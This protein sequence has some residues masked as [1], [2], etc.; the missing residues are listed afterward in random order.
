MALIGILKQSFTI[1]LLLCKLIGSKEYSPNA[2]GD[3]KLSE[4][5]RCKVL[6]ESFNHWLDKTSRGKYE[7]GDAAWE[8]AKLKSYARSEV[9]LVEIQEGLC[10]E[11][12][13]HQDACYAVAEESEQVLEKWWFDV[14]SV[15]LD[16]YTWLC[17]E[18]LQ[19]CCPSNHYGIDCSPCP[20][21]KY[22]KICAGHGKCDGAGTRKG[23]GTCICRKGY[24]GVICDECATGFYQTS[25]SLCKACHK[26]CNGCNGDGAASCEACNEGWELQ[27]G[28]CLDVNECASS[29]CE[30]HQYCTNIEGSYKCFDCD[31]SCNTCAGEGSSNCTACEPSKVLWFA[32]G[33]EIFTQTVKLI[34]Q[35]LT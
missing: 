17:I 1:L 16:L 4:C 8:E 28:M 10:S 20:Q 24:K 35:T 14:N 11:L 18:T 32:A 23:N 12:K 5:R 15:S 25:D 19:Q 7:G 13:I 27:S 34:Q 9:R 33:A 31:T 29:V 30:H 26:A 6:T 21:D 22:N 3:Q 2:N